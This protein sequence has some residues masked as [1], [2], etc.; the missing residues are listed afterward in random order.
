[1]VTAG[2]LRGCGWAVPDGF[3]EGLS[4]YER[5]FVRLE[6]TGLRT[7][8]YY[9]ERVRYVGFCGLGRVLDA[10]CGMGQWSA[11]LAE[12][13]RA[14]AGVDLNG[15]R[16]GLARRLASELGQ[17]NLDFQA[18]RLEA[19]PY[20]SAAFDGVFCYGVF[21]FTHMPRTLAE[22]RRVLRPG[23]RLYVNANSWGWYVHLLRDVP[24]N[25]R[26]AFGILKNTVLRRKQ[27]IVVGERWLRARL[28]DHG[29]EV[30]AVAAEGGASFAPPT[31][32]VPPAPAYPAAYGG[33]RAILEA[34]ATRGPA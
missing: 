4:D 15:G 7:L 33:L 29:F 1:M 21:M 18:G 25:R 31:A 26:A 23:G 28:R 14:V 8:P 6:F 2:E 17:R 30:V 12:C 13:N 10:G 34:V 24:W 3:L 20:A 16:L 5:E 11:A 19:L 27:A 22:F 9:C 32:R